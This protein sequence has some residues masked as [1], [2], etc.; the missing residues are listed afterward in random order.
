MR[1]YPVTTCSIDG[2]LTW[3]LEPDTGMLTGMLPNGAKLVMIAI[4]THRLLKLLSEYEE[5]I[6]KA[7]EKLYYKIGEVKKP[8]Y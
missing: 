5:A 2:R 6:A 4:D 8:L 7:S 1:N 3:V